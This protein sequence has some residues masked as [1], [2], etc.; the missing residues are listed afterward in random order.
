MQPVGISVLTSDLILFVSSNY[1]ESAKEIVSFATTST[2]IFNIFKQSPENLSFRSLAEYPNENNLSPK[3]FY[4]KSKN[5]LQLPCTS[6][7][8]NG[9]KETV[10]TLCKFLPRET[11][12]IIEGS[13]R[14]SIG[15]DANKMKAI[16][17]ISVE[18]LD[19]APANPK[20]AEIKK[21]LGPE[22]AASELEI[23]DRISKLGGSDGLMQAAY[24]KLAASRFNPEDIPAA[25]AE[26]QKL[27]RELY[28]LAIWQDNTIVGGKL[29]EVRRDLADLDEAARR[30]ATQRGDFF[31]EL[32]IDVPAHQLRT[33][34]EILNAIINR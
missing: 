12:H 13:L 33:R 15:A 4:F 14:S 20:V 8:V 2:R 32:C 27:A 28:S 7:T 17:T 10:A 21:A 30:L 19:P 25:E 3:I 22:L 26:V 16:A 6:I 34:C 18:Y 31:V 11:L 24:A 5:F 1:L 29:F 23:I 9:F